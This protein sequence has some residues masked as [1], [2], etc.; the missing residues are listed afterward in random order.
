M[1]ADKPRTA[2]FGNSVSYI[3]G[4]GRAKVRNED[5]TK[6]ATNLEPTGKFDPVAREV[7]IVPHGQDIRGFY[8][9]EDLTITVLCDGHGAYEGGTKYAAYTAALVPAVIVAAWT[10]IRKAARGNNPGAIKACLD[11]GLRAMD[12]WLREEC[13]ETSG[14]SNGG[15]TCTFNIKFAHP[16]RPQHVVSITGNV[17]DSPM[18]VLNRDSNDVEEVTVEFNADNRDAYKVYYE[19]CL[20]QG[21]RPKEAHLGR[22]NHP[23]QYQVR[24]MTDEFGDLEPISVYDPRIVEGQAVIEQNPK[25]RKFYDGSNQ[26]HKGY[27]RMG[28]FQSHRGREANKAEQRSGVC[29]A[30]NYGC[31][32][33]GGTQTLGGIGDKGCRSGYEDVFPFHLDY[34][35]L[36]GTT[37]EVMGSDGVFD[38]LTDPE[39][40]KALMESGQHS[41]K[42]AQT[43]N[44]KMMDNARTIRNGESQTGPLMFPMRGGNP[45]WDDLSMWVMITFPRPQKKGKTKRSRGR[46]T[47]AHRFKARTPEP[48]RKCLQAKLKISIEAAKARG[49][50]AE[51]V[52]LAHGEMKEHCWATK[53]VPTRKVGLRAASSA[54]QRQHNSGEQGW[55]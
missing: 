42:L 50:V 19:Q 20:E 34:R 55:A 18:V 25:M 5:L 13:P 10:S 30:I 21:L 24:W 49:E 2:K 1:W 51:Q 17:G 6:F 22:W 40:L 33:E 43:I 54:V 16:R 7:E 12:K 46:T 39:L 28:G 14:F 47:P 8:Q 27:Q 41:G 32:L 48:V 37:I 38:C 53:M 4:M 44:R 52:R 45:A 36:K 15:T 26:L 9:N 3:D 35:E 31:T 11:S 23:G 29:S